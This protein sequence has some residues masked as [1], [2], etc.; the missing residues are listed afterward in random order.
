LR[1]SSAPRAKDEG[2]GR[3]QDFPGHPTL[4]SNNLLVVH[5][6]HAN[7]RVWRRQSSNWNILETRDREC[8]RGISEPTLTE[9]TYHLTIFLLTS[10]FVN[11]AL[12]M[13]LHAADLAPQQNRKPPCRRSIKTPHV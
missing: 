3:S 4:G 8:D 1:P 2:A 10:S 9:L 13:R 12:T 11:T 5:R 7:W 6:S